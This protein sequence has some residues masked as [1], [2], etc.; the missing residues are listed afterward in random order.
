MTSRITPSLRVSANSYNRVPWDVA[1]CCVKSP[2]VI[3]SGI[4]FAFVQSAT[5]FFG[6]W[7]NIFQRYI[8]LSHENVLKSYPVHRR[9]IPF[10]ELCLCANVGFPAC[11]PAANKQP[12]DLRLQSLQSCFRMETLYFQCLTLGMCYHSINY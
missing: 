12:A 10:E 9:H 11:L 6:V 8:S 3:S 4:F 2:Y 1:L 5:Y 7:R